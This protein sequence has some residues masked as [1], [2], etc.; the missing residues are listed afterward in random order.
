M[1]LKKIQANQPVS[2][3]S[4]LLS[5]TFKKMKETKFVCSD[6][7]KLLI[8]QQLLIKS[9]NTIFKQFCTFATVQVLSVLCKAHSKVHSLYHQLVISIALRR[10]E[11]IQ[12]SYS[13]KIFKYN[14]VEYKC[15]QISYEKCN[16]IQKITLQ[17]PRASNGYF[18]N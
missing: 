10:A 4:D 16:Q 9:K 8:T 18:T 12:Q 2:A 15:D 14:V 7:R 1:L 5:C 11:I 6:N 3:Y 17:A 13:I